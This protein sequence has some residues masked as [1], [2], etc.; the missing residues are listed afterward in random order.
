MSLESVLLVGSTKVHSFPHGFPWPL[1][2]DYPIKDTDRYVV[3]SEYAYFRGWD[4]TSL[5]DIFYRARKE[6]I[7]ECEETSFLDHPY[8]YPDWSTS[9]WKEPLTL[10]VHELMDA[11]WEVTYREWIQTLRIISAPARHYDHMLSQF[12]VERESGE[13]DQYGAIAG[14][15]GI[16][17]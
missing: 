17:Q 12:P 1:I 7:D 15:L 3:L 11:E 10:N 5:I 13:P 4:R 8:A 16:L 14:E 9:W 2:L 6:A